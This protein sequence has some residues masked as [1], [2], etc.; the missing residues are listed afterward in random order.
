M[1]ALSSSPRTI[2]YLTDDFSSIFDRAWFKEQGI[3]VREPKDS[4]VKVEVIRKGNRVHVNYSTG[5]SE[6]IRVP[7]DF[8]RRATGR[9]VTRM[10]GSERNKPCPCG[11]GEKYKHCHGV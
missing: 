3:E 8:V 11:S 6:A 5:R 1:T 9:Q 2:S 10:K 4:P 7:P